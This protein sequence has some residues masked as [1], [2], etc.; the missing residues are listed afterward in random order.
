[1]DLTTQSTPALLLDINI[2]KRNI[3]NMAIRARR[4]GVA[5]R[6]H[7]KTHKCLEV[8]RLQ[9]ESGARG[10]TVSTLTEGEI[11]A[12]AGFNDITY[13]VPLEPGKIQR[14]LALASQVNL[15]ITV[16]DL[17]LV[18][19]LDR[20]AG[21]K[22]QRLKTWLKVDGGYHRAGVDPDSAYA[23][24]LAQAIAGA[25]HLDF[26]G[27]LTHAGHAYK[28][29]AVSEIRAIAHEERLILTRFAAQLRTK[30][31]QVPVLSVG[32]TPT[33]A[34]A[35]DLEGIDEARPGNYV[36]HDRTQLALGSCQPEDC[37]LTVMAT[38]ISHQPGRNQ[39][40]IDAGALALSQ[41]PGPA[42]LDSTPNWGAI[43]S[44]RAN[45]SLYTSFNVVAISQE[46]GIIKG[47]SAADVADLPVGCRVIILPNHSCLTAAQFD[48]Y[49][50]VDG[51]LVVDMWKIQRERN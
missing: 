6:P 18:D 12:R 11:F 27:L 13:A 2:L 22:K 35:T 31:I 44:D 45:M 32:A 29:A 39:V 41:D 50:V 8:A 26:A 37:A 5:L 49:I 24:Q 9:R 42:H 25:Q 23:P 47:K 40:V 17:A 21:V 20:S 34:V 28:A 33:M 48:E 16:D 4:L 10:I 30:G 3:A 43:V 14:A 1:M 7:I 15:G 51:E 19:K 46:H 38:V 36:F